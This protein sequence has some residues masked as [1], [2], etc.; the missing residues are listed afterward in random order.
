[1]N[2]KPLLAKKS[3]EEKLI[4]IAQ[5]PIAEKDLVKSAPKSEILENPVLSSVIDSLDEVIKIYKRVGFDLN[6]EI[7]DKIENVAYNILKDKT[8]KKAIFNEIMEIGWPIWERKL[9]AFLE[10][11]RKSKKV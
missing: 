8:S 6:A 10:K 9:N 3:I 11:N 7:D 2:R 4:E 1:M 5:E